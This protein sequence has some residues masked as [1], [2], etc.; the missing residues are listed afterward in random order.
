MHRD[1]LESSLV[2]QRNRTS[3]G[4][5]EFDGALEKL[6]GTIR[7]AQQTI[8]LPRQFRERLGAPSV[9]LGQVQVVRHFKHHRNL[10]G[11]SAGAANILLRDAGAVQPVEHAEHS[12]DA[13]F[14]A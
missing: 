4:S 10:G 13:P 3:A 2:K 1:R 12:Q 11:Q 9:L 14:G 5:R 8:D 6:A 7:Q